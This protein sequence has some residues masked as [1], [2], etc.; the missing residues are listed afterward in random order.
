MGDLDIAERRVPQD[1]RVVAARSRATRSTSASSRCRRPAARASSCACST[2]SQV[3]LDARR[4]RHARRGAREPLRGAA[5]ARPTAPCS[6]PGRPAPASPPRSTPRSTR[7][8]RSRRTSSRSRTR[9]ST[10]SPGINQ[11]QVNPKAGL[12]FATGLRSMLRADPDIIMVGEIRDAETAQIADRVGA[13][14]PPRALDAAHQRRAVGD[15]PPHRDGH[16]AVPHRLG[17][18]LRRRPAPRAAALHLL[19][20]AHGPHR[21]RAQG[22]P[23]STTPRSTS[24]PTSPSAARAAATRATRAAS[25]STRS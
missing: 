19:Q 8:T 22:A 11:M 18:R 10:S 16:R 12:T 23:A 2:R 4:A 17:P 21:R 7:S 6:S 15:H 25:A 9:S 13:H 24:R 5:S 1:G 20:A 3:L 14:R